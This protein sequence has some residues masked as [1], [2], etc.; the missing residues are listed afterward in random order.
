MIASLLR[1][2]NNGRFAQP[3]NFM[4]SIRNAT[5]RDADAIV[6]LVQSAYRGDASRAGWTT[7]ADLIDGQRTDIAEV[8]ELIHQP[9]SCIL[10]C[11]QQGRLLASVHLQDREHYGYLGMFAVDPE[12]QGGGVGKYLLA[13]AEHRVFHVWQRASLQMTVISLRRELI[14]WYQRRGYQP[15]DEYLPFP[16]G[17][18]RYGLPRRDDLRLQVL[19]K[20]AAAVD[21]VAAAM[22]AG[23]PE[24]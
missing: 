1:F 5:D 16:Y 6:R 24:N 18:P 8:C 13:Q 10:L 19:R 21:P 15:T 12:A 2:D 20:Q 4:Y 9:N 7:E 22:P 11:E 3:L 14:A 23:E 17:Q